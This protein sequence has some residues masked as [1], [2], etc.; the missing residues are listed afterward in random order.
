MRIY[1]RNAL[2]QVLVTIAALTA[3][4]WP[5]RADPPEVSVIFVI[6]G[7]TNMSPRGL[8]YFGLARDGIARFLSKPGIPLGDTFEFTVIQFAEFGAP[9]YEEDKH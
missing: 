6:D 2:L 3:A 4:A 1:D 7:S 8:D 9:G 5:G